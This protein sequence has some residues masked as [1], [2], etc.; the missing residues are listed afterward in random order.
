[1][2]VRSDFIPTGTCT[3]YSRYAPLV[4]LLLVLGQP[5]TF[6]RLPVIDQLAVDDQAGSPKP[7][8]HLR[9]VGKSSRA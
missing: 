4:V 3:M 2:D 7:S 1:M 8:L 5:W 9:A 6:P